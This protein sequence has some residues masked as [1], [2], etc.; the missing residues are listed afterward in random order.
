MK[1]NE[2]IVLVSQL[3]NNDKKAFD[4]L[5]YRYS[6]KLYSFSFSFLKNEEDS[7]EIVQEVFFRVWNKR[8]E[9]NSTKS[10]KSYL[11]K[12]SYN[13]IIDQLRLKLKNN[14]YQKFLKEYFNTNKSNQNIQVDYEIIHGLIK[15][16]IN[17]LPPK[18][19][20]IFIMS[21]E[22][23]Y[24]H[25]EIAEKMGI[26]AKTIENQITLAIKHIKTKL[27]KDVFSLF[28]FLSLFF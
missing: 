27:G 17:E 3:I 28:L 1:D 13:L 2:E 21:R 25:K 10:F 16:A 12:I 9:I 11:F 18:R 26:S 6:Q 19:K 24:S 14:E 7:K 23:G 8:H 4:M 15:N 5:Y 22:K 20:N